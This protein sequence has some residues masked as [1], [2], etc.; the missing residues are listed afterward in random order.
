M[1]L[2]DNFVGN[3]VDNI[4]GSHDVQEM[5]CINRS[6]L[7]ALVGAG[8]L[9]PIKELKRESLFWKPSVEQLRSE[10]IKDSRTNLFKQVKGE[11]K[12]A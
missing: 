3:V 11:L 12:D 1:E 4:L 8:K 7:N 9:K 2:L 6:R 5:L 10:M